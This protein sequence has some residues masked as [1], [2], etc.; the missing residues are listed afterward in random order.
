M[1]APQPLPDSG[2]IWHFLPSAGM[3]PSVKCLVTRVV[4]LGSG[5]LVYRTV[6]WSA[7]E[8]EGEGTLQLE[9]VRQSTC[10]S[11]VQQTRSIFLVP[12]YLRVVRCCFPVLV[13]F[14][15]L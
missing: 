7:S 9:G 15:R 2:L 1:R 5:N 6:S 10:A 3:S 4:H 8:G 12:P 11:A 14:Y 13:L